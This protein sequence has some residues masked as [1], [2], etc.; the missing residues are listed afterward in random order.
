MHGPQFPVIPAVKAIIA[1]S[2]RRAILVRV[3]APLVADA[4]ALNSVTQLYDAIFAAKA[5]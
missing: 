3:R 4:A 1:A 5:A 2:H